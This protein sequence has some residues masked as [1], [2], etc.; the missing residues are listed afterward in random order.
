VYL[1]RYCRRRG[2]C[3]SRFSTIE[4]LLVVPLLHGPVRGDPGYDLQA[5]SDSITRK[6]RKD[7]HYRLRL[8]PSPPRDHKSGSPKTPQ[9][10]LFPHFALSDVRAFRVVRGMTRPN[11]ETDG[12]VASRHR[13]GGYKGHGINPERRLPRHQR[14]RPTVLPAPKRV[15]WPVE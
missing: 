4:H 6:L 14:P 5:M 8:S 2:F 3:G 9:E 15:L 12:M 1:P 7:Q 11:P 10:P 13:S